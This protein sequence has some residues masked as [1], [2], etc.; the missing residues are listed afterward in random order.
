M[1]KCLVSAEIY[2]EEDQELEFKWRERNVISH[3]VMDQKVVQMQICYSHK[4]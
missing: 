4:D 3:L 2:L 1:T